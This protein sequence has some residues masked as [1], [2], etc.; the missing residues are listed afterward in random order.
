MTE[1]QPSATHVHVNVT[2]VN[3]SGT[4]RAP[5]CGAALLLAALAFIAV[6][7]WQAALLI[8]LVVAIGIY[9]GVRRGGRI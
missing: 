7:S 8:G 5:G 9:F 3:Q 1:P 2:Q 4:Q 6:S